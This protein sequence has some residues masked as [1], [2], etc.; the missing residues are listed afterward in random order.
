MAIGRSV[1]TGKA[2]NTAGQRDR[3]VTIERKIAPDEADE[4]YP[5][6]D[7]EELRKVFMFRRDLRADERVSMGQE[8]AFAETTWQSE[9]MADMDPELVDL[10][11]TTRI[12]YAG[13]AYNIVAASRMERKS[14]LEFMTLA[15]TR[16]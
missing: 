5:V 6:E 2:S 9:Y 13:R 11:A 15:G 10:P 12:V 4:G 3:Y 14:G 7:W 8:S 1:L 16:I